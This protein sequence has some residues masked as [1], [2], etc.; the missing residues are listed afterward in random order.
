MRLMI[1]LTT[2]WLTGFR[3]QLSFV[4]FDPVFIGV[5]YLRS[6]CLVKSTKEET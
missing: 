2:S 6:Q 3:I 5:I 4:Q 1:P